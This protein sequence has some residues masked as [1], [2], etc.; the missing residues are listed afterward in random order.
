MNNH[1]GKGLMKGVNMAGPCSETMLGKF[2]NDYIRGFVIGY[3]Y[4]LE[5]KTGEKSVAAL[6]AGR[7]TRQYN[8]DREIMAEFFLEFRT[9]KFLHYFNI[10]YSGGS[11]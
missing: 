9:D 2:C 11:N 1:F 5:Q 7:V 4:Q 3:C 10:G 6:E 8:L